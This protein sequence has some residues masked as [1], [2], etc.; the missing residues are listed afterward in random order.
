MSAMPKL[1]NSESEGARM[2]VGQ[3]GALESG[4]GSTFKRSRQK[5]RFERFRRQNHLAFMFCYVPD[6]PLTSWDI[7]MSKIGK[8]ICSPR[9]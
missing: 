3:F 9:S 6:T 7:K 8:F 5:G 2:S 1:R 4:G